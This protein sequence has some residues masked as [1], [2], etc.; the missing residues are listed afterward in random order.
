MGEENGVTGWRD[1]AICGGNLNFV[2]VGMCVNVIARK[3]FIKKVCKISTIEIIGIFNEK[4]CIEEK[5]N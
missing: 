2:L 4:V 1:N 3:F 5:E